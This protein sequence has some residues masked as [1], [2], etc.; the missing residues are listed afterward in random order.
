MSIEL[1]GHW[2]REAVQHVREIAAFCGAGSEFSAREVLIGLRDSIAVAVARKGNSAPSRHRTASPKAPS[3]PAATTACAISNDC[4][5]QHTA[6][7][8]RDQD[9]G[10]P[11]EGA[12]N[13]NDVPSLRVRPGRLAAKVGAGEMTE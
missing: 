10:A 1:L 8:P 3:S 13:R 5:A 4:S 12:G 11:Q 9:H 2:D 7:R 6:T